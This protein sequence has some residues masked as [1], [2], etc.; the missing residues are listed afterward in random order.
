MKPR[1]PEVVHSAVEVHAYKNHV[2][3]IFPVGQSTIGI[4]FESPEQMVEFFSAVMEKAVQVW[5]NNE[6]IKEYMAS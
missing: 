5:P 2:T 3:A 6:W 4:R 1:I